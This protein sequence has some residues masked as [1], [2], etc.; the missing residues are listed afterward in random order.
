MTLAAEAARFPTSGSP[1]AAAD[2]LSL[3]PPAVVEPLVGQAQLQAAMTLASTLPPIWRTCMLEV[4]LGGVSRQVDFMACV[5]DVDRDR[6]AVAEALP[7]L[8]PAHL[9]SAQALLRAWAIRNAPAASAVPIVWLEW[10]MPYA[11]PALPLFSACLDVSL[12]DA[13]QAA[14]S[15]A[16]QAGIADWLLALVCD[17]S[18]ATRLGRGLATCLGALPPDARLLHVAPLHARGLDRLRFTLGL[19]PAELLTWLRV[20]EWPGD[21]TAVS[22]W[23]ARLAPPWHR[24]FFQVEM[25]D[26][27]HAHLSI[28]TRVIATAAQAGDPWSVVLETFEHAGLVDPSL[29]IAVAS[30]P[31]SSELVWGGATA[32][33]A[34][35]CYLKLVLNGGV[36]SEVKAYL[37]MARQ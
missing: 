36:A 17:A 31:G 29:A 22:A 33:L 6:D 35:S 18:T 23:V 21:L 8:P 20:I 2:A 15:R 14:P 16:V 4:R 1:I 24:V 37:G 7:Q 3:L 5:A 30:W 26:R 34:R 12:L 25:D 11:K 9:G 13:G 32:K 19:L 10:D 28:E 27:V